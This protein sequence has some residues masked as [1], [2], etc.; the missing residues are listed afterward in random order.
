MHEQG[1]LKS[2]NAIIRPSHN[3]NFILGHERKIMECYNLIKLKFI[4]EENDPTKEKMLKTKMGNIQ[5]LRNE[6]SYVKDDR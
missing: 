5:A 6:D 4:V 2:K 3:E 1:L